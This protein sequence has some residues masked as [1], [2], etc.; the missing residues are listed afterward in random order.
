M[1]AKLRD[2]K[3]RARGREQRPHQTRSLSCSNLP[4]IEAPTVLVMEAI[5]R[6]VL[7]G[8]VGILRHGPERQRLNGFARGREMAIIF[9]VSP[10]A[11]YKAPRPAPGQRRQGPG[12]EMHANFIA[13]AENHKAIVTLLKE[14]RNIAGAG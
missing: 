9:T 1:E 8:T 3:P 13:R 6:V 10:G 5:P 12:I 14:F 2:L 7:V 11:Q 4:G